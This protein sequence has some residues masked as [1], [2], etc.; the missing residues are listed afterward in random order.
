MNNNVAYETNSWVFYEKFGPRIT[1]NDWMEVNPSASFN[2]TKSASTLSTSS[3]TDFKT[4]TTALNI[5]GKFYFLKGFEL[6]YSASKNFVTGINANITS[7]PL[8][9]NSYLQRDFWH[10]RISATVQVFDILNQ[11]NFVNRDVNVD[12][13]YTDTKSNALSRYF[14]FRLSANLQKWT[15]ARGRNGNRIMRRG[16]GSFMN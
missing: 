8:V 1:P 13:S 4:K 11:N 3:S 9:I 10:R 6:G 15:G 12:G 16:D 14:M 5:D 2:F 7:N